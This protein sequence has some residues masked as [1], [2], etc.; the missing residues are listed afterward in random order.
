MGGAATSL[1]EHART[2]DGERPDRAAASP[3]FAH[4]RGGIVLTN[5]IPYVPLVT[6]VMSAAFAWLVFARYWEK[7]RAGDPART[8]LAWWAFGIAMFG[9]GTLAEG[10][11]TLVGW[12]EPIFR[13]WY[14]AGALLGGA[15]LAQGSVYLLMR[16]RVADRL[17]IVAFS[18]VAV[19]AVFVLLAP[20]ASEEATDVL[21]GRVLEW[22]WVR[23]LSPAINTYAFVFLVGGAIYSAARY[24]RLPDGDAR[25]LGNVL[26][27]VGALL[28]GIGGSFSRAGNTEVLYVTEFVGLILI[29]IGY[30]ASIGQSTLG[31]RRKQATPILERA[32]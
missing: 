30:R 8:H 13:W 21:S 11:T 29:Y 4:N 7:R 1:N 23:L 5:A 10:L 9:A 14:I 19:A 15:P 27:A 31:M 17:A 16:K 26:I 28:P 22:E 2:C 18:Y 32:S 24:W 25:A 12:Q 6:T 20:V 3:S